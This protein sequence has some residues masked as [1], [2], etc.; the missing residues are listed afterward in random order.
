MG[1]IT[2]Y[3]N[4]EL[5]FH[6]MRLQVDAKVGSRM[7]EYVWPARK[8]R[9]LAAAGASTSETPAQR[10]SDEEPRP[11]RKSMDSSRALNGSNG[12]KPPALRRL[13][14]S[15]SFTDL[16]GSIPSDSRPPSRSG[17]PQRTRTLDKF[18]SRS[19]TNLLD[20]SEGQIKKRQVSARKAGDA[21]EMKTR[22]SQKTFILVKISRQ[23]LAT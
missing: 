6:P 7:L 22:S 16:R 14:T 5:S 2:I 18:R 10:K 19:Q 9:A 21:A 1:G 8:Q 3:Q 23:V 4:F 11:S 17:T 20:P 12:L 15:R 13:G